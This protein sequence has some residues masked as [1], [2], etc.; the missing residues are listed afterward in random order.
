MSSEYAKAQ[1]TARSV[2][3]QPALRDGVFVDMGIP[4]ADT[5]EGAASRASRTKSGGAFHAGSVAS[6]GGNVT[7][8]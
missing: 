3:E 7:P 1:V 6:G 5:E 2:I 4:A 8:A